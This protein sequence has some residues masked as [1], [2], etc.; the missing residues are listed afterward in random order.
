M[1]SQN[2]LILFSSPNCSVCKSLHPKIRDAFETSFPL[3]K[4]REIDLSEKPEASATYAVYS[5]PATLLILEGKEYLRLTGSFS[6]NELTS[7]T[8]RYYD[9]LFS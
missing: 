4:V 2:Q 9:M 7:K 1:K 8:Q 3:L 6:I 5:V